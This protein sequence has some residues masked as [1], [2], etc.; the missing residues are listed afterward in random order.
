MPSDYDGLAD[1]Y[2]LWCEAD[3]SATPS[4]AFYVER[5]CRQE[6]ERVELGVGTGRI[7]IPV[8]QRGGQLTG[9][10][11]SPRMLDTCREKA[12]RA[13]VRSALRLLHQDVRTLELGAPADL[14]TFP[15]R[16][17]GHLLTEEDKL[18][19]FRSVYFNL[20]PGG[21]FVFDHYV[22]NEAWARRFDGVSR[23]MVE[24]DLGDFRLR[25]S[26][27]YRYNYDEQSMDC[28]IR[29]QQFAAGSELLL[30]ERVQQFEFTWF[31]VDQVRR[32]ASVTGF[33]VEALHGSF[34]TSCDFGPEATDQVWTLRRPVDS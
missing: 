30:R 6:R 32:W 2:D 3:P 5:L 34:D 31:D 8:L 22:W 27:L 28:S 20:A 13:G 14:I 23:L 11:A 19:C 17:I 1:I 10:D 21:R 9:V 33:E 29:I 4:L 12:G 7:A 16:S 18:A 24:R 25:I 26:D 15:F